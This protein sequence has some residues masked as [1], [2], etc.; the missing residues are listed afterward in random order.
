M[1]APNIIFTYKFFVDNDTNKKTYL[2]PRVEDFNFIDDLGSD[3]ILYSADN[4]REKFKD[5]I[6]KAYKHSN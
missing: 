1:S 5:K 3:L 2:K 6:I 4:Y